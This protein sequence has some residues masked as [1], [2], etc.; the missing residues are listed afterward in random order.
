MLLLKY[1]YKQNKKKS[2]QNFAL[3]E[4]LPIIID[5]FLPMIAFLQI[6][7]N[8]LP[9]YLFHHHLTTPKILTKIILILYKNTQKNAKKNSQNP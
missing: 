1:L 5:R 8:L 7:S 9:F 6:L 4:Q 3:D 2:R